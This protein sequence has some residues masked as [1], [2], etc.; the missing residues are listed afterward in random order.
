MTPLID[1][2]DSASAVPVSALGPYAFV[3]RYVSAMQPKCITAPEA[4]GYAAAGKALVLVYEDG[5]EDAL[6]G[7]SIGAAKAAVARPVLAS[8]AWPAGRPVYFACDFT[9]ATDQLAT[10]FQ[11]VAAFAAGVG[12]PAALYGDA[13]MCAYAA[14]RGVPYR[15]QFGPGLAPGRVIQQ[16]TP[17]IIVGGVACDPDTAYADDY[18]Q[19]PWEPTVNLSDHTFVIGPDGRAAYETNVPFL[20]AFAPTILEGLDTVAFAQPPRVANASGHAVIVIEGAT[21]GV[22]VTVRLASTT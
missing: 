13:T 16:G 20:N 10:A 6:G 11:C 3:A 21:P 2:V 5:A 8:I 19:S 17:E 9:P 18:G 15:W 1:G 22:K 4:H 14:S 7:A 12:R